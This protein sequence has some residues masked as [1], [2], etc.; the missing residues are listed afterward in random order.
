[1]VANSDMKHKSKTMQKVIRG[2]MLDWV[3]YFVIV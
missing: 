1:M 3:S 2:L